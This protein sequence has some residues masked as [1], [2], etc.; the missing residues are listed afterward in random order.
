VKREEK[1]LQQTP[2]R[3][4]VPGRDSDSNPGGEPES[5]GLL[6]GEGTLSEIYL[7]QR[8]ICA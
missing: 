7:H 3:R 4:N 5:V 6:A 2:T 8:L 1:S